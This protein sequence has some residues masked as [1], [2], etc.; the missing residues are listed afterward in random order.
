VQE[1]NGDYG[2]GYVIDVLRGVNSARVREN[3]H[4]KCTSFGEGSDQNADEWTSVLRQ[5]VHHGY[6][7][8]NVSRKAALMPSEKA[9]A[10]VTGQEMVMLAKYKPGIKRQLKRL[11][12]SRDEALFGWL[13]GLRQTLADAEGT[14]PHVLFSDATLS[15]MSQRKPVDLESLARVSGVG[16][17]KLETYGQDLIEAVRQHLASQSD[18]ADASGDGRPKLMAKGPAA[19]DSQLHTLALY[20]NLGQVGQIAVQQGV[21]EKTVLGHFIALIRAGHYIDVP[22]LFGGMFEQ[23]MADLDQA[24]PYASLSEVKRDLSIDISNEEFRLLLAW[25]EAIGV[26]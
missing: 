13:V 16:K 9:D 23:L 4:D 8:Q 5:L 10:L 12:G 19:N 25:R 7:H 17:H 3:G 1:L 15:E 20:K 11:S 18:K 21:S 24:D 22:D 14:A 26:A 2:M 6:M